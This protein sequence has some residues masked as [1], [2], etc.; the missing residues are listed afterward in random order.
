[1]K[2]I[3]VLFL[4]VVSL[5]RLPAGSPRPLSI[6]TGGRHATSRAHAGFNIHSTAKI[7]TS[8]RKTNKFYRFSINFFIHEALFF[9]ISIIFAK[10][11]PR[12]LRRSKAFRAEP[13]RRAGPE[14]RKTFC[15]NLWI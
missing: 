4:I 7:K 14:P 2:F 13:Q 10:T 11:T 15:F 8:F 6:P 9:K 1:M 5:L 3:S 12:S